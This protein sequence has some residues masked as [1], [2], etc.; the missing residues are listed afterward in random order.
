MAKTK[1]G[2]L[3]NPTDA[4][5]KEQHRKQVNR[6]KLERK[7]QREAHSKINNAS[8]LKDE[9]SSIIHAEESGTIN[10]TLRLKKKVLQDAYDHALKKQKETETRTRQD[11]ED[12]GS[13]ELDLPVPP[14][15][16]LPLGPRPSAVGQ[17]PPL[18]FGLPPPP[19]PPPGF[20]LPPPPGPPPCFGLPPPAGPPPG[21]G[22]PRPFHLPMQNT[23]MIPGEF[24]Y[25]EDS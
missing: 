20:G 8:S 23:H 3:M 25:F 9:L 13:L 4:Y 12:V 10:K 19:G 11:S 1:N 14:P 16:P 7:L 2:R 22:F 6:N 24:C 17:V 15:P 5:R 18:G 21:V